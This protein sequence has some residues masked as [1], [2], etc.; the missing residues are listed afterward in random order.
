MGFCKKMIVLSK[1]S[2]RVTD[3]TVAMFELE[4]YPL[5]LWFWMDMGS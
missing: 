3:R 5:K 1:E 4:S 2:T